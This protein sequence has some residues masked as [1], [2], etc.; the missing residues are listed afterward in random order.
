[1]EFDGTE[2][3]IIVKSERCTPF[4]FYNNMHSMRIATFL[5]GRSEDDNVSNMQT[6][7]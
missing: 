7:F 3:T 6:L 1:M 5:F 4:Y 2:D